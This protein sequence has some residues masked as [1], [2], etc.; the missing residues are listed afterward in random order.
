MLGTDPAIRVMSYTTESSTVHDSSHS[1]AEAS[2]TT[3]CTV[4]TTILNGH[5]FDVDGVVVRDVLPQGSTDAKIVVALRKPEGL[6]LAKEGEDVFIQYVMAK[7]EEAH[8]IA[9]W[10]KAENGSGGEKD[11]M[12]EFVCG[13]RAGQKATLEV[14]WDIKAPGNMGWEEKVGWS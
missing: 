5:A 12:Y 9:R 2:K 3:T 14:E 10:T 11:G 1:F 4:R 6:A 8:V 13:V 7:N